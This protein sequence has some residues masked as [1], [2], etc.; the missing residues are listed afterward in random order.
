LAGGAAGRTSP[1]RR[2]AGA[3][4]DAELREQAEG[5]QAMND[6]GGTAADR[7]QSFVERVEHLEAERRALGE[8][9][10]DVKAEA[11]GEVPNAAGE[12]RRICEAHGGLVWAK[13]RRPDTHES[14]RLALRARIDAAEGLRMPAAGP[15]GT[16]A[17]E[18]ADVD[19]AM[20]GEG[21]GA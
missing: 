17:G 2:H 18:D 10:K 5:I 4:I 15:A 16:D 11:R 12:A 20:V 6:I 7:L 1:G 3:G 21:D 9:I 13:Q 8:D 19:P 14:V